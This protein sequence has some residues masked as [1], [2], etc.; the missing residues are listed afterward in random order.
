M[1][2]Q[3]IIKKSWYARII[4]GL[5]AVLPVLLSLML[6]LSGSIL[7]TLIFC[8]AALSWTL[9]TN[10]LSK[11]PDGQ[12]YLS[13]HDGTWVFITQET[14]IRGKQRKQSFSVGGVLFLSIEDSK[15]EQ[16]NLWLF[17]DSVHNSQ[18]GWRHLHTC[19]YLSS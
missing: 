18:Q 7:L 15:G 4:I 13:W 1:Q 19:Y 10:V 9:L 5:L 16:H 3:W 6:N 17:P 2:L 14:T 12:G 8:S 11:L